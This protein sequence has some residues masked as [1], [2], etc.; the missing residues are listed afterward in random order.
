MTNSEDPRPI[1]VL[2]NDEVEKLA[3][4]RSVKKYVVKVEAAA[5]MLNLSTRSVKRMVSEGVLPV[6]RLRGTGKTYFMLD[7]IDALF[8]QD[9]QSAA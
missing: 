3:L 9:N 1:R 6:Y 7:D 5:R 2:S 8:V 4:D